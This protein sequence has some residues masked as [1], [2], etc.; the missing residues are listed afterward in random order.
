MTTDAARPPRVLVA[1][2]ITEEQRG[3]L[4]GWTRA[5]ALQR[6]E[7][8][9]DVA[10]TDASAGPSPGYL[11]W[12]T[13]WSKSMPF[14][15]THRIRL[16]RLSDEGDEPELRPAR[17][18]RLLWDKFAAWES[19]DHLLLLDVDVRPPP[20]LLQHLHG[21]GLAWAVALLRGAVLPMRCALLDGRLVR[22]LPFDLALDGDLEYSQTCISAGVFPALVP[23]PQ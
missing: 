20:L 6:T 4:A 10:I 13:A 15:P 18:R 16:L 9:Y 12:L 14:G 21:A 2:A 1:T 11:A 8:L 3:E 5:L 7:L 22:G 19:Y 17:A 23:I